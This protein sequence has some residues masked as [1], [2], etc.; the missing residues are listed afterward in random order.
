MASLNNN[1]KKLWDQHSAE[2]I[3]RQID[4]A[5]LQNDINTRALD[6]AVLKNTG[7]QTITNGNLTLGSANRLFHAWQQVLRYSVS[8]STLNLYTN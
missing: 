2:T 1:L 5:L 8:G 3:S 7:N 4:I 6:S